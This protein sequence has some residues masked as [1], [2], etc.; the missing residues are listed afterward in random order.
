MVIRKQKGFINSTLNYILTAVEISKH[1]SGLL[2][3]NK[4]FE[5]C[6]AFI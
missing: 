1:I 3:L 4:I 5:F 2:Y 6:S